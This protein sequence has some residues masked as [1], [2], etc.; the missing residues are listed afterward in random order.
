MNLRLNSSISTDNTWCTSTFTCSVALV[1]Y[2]VYIPKKENTH[3]PNIL[4]VDLDMFYKR[5]PLL[6][7]TLMK[8]KNNM[9]HCLQATPKC[10]DKALKVSFT[11]LTAMS[12][13]EHVVPTRILQ[14]WRLFIVHSRWC[15]SC[16][17]SI[18]MK[19]S[20]VASRFISGNGCWWKDVNFCR[21]VEKHRSFSWPITC[22]GFSNVSMPLSFHTYSCFFSFNNLCFHNSR[23]S[24]LASWKHW[25]FLRW[26]KEDI[27]F[28]PWISHLPTTSV[29]FHWEM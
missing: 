6:F 9:F 3:Y 5:N 23:T 11:T 24:R 10:L 7:K 28:W 14:L 17:L 2:S 20:V 22:L 21:L 19:C 1:T 29:V 18:C 13:P 25:Q 8:V 26:E 15:L 4:S 12:V 27:F 16:S